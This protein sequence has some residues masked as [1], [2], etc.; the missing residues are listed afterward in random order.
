M[1]NMTRAYVSMTVRLMSMFSNAR[2][3]DALP[4]L[5]GASTGSSTQRDSGQL[6]AVVIAARNA[7]RHR[8]GVGTVLRNIAARVQW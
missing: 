7:N 1:D 4:G 5:C 3:I 8:Q 6:T 2:T